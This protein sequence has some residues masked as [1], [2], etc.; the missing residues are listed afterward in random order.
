MEGLEEKKR[1][2]GDGGSTRL[3]AA[4]R[5]LTPHSKPF[6]PANQEPLLCLKDAR[7][8]KRRRSLKKR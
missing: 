5:P 8:K 6:K 2:P 1:G 3:A 7:E 4:P